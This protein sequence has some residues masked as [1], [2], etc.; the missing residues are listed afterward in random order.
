MSLAWRVSRLAFY[1]ILT[2]VLQEKE[3]FTSIRFQVDVTK[4]GS[5][6]SITPSWIT[7]YFVGCLKKSAN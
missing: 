5:Q 6:N 2:K 1:F 3:K 4:E 7:K